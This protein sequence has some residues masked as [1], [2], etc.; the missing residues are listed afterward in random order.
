DPARRKPV[1]PMLSPLEKKL[2]NITI[3]VQLVLPD[4]STA[5]PADYK[6][7][8]TFRDSRAMANVIAGSIGSIG[9]DYVE[10][11]IDLDGTM[12]DIMAAAGELLSNS[13][14]NGRHAHW[15]AALFKHGISLARHTI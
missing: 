4:G 14:L 13:P 8:L 3:P 5:G 9:Q 2:E 10:G 7:R 12:R 15:F 11:R 6:V 1:N